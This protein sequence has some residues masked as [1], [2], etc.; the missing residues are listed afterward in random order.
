MVNELTERQTVRSDPLILFLTHTLVYNGVAMMTDSW[1]IKS[2]LEM[3][4]LFNLYSSEDSRGRHTVYKRF[5]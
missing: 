1:L 3:P 2:Q 5:N 4:T